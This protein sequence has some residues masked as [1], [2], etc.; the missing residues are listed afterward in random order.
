MSALPPEGPKNW[1]NLGYALLPVLIGSVLIGFAHH[2]PYETIVFVLY[3]I[4]FKMK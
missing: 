4:F 1:E 2:W 3:G